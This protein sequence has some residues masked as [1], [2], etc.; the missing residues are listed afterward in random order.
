MAPA[1][2]SGLGIA[3]RIAHLTYRS[4]QELET[5]FSRH[6]QSGEQPLADGRYAVQSYLDHQANKLV[7]RFDAGSY[8][9]LTD[10]MNTHDLGRGRGGVEAALASITGADRGR[11]RRLRPAVSALPAGADRDARRPPATGCT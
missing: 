10:A 9:A 1:R 2:R 3:R 4:E 6:P 7:N 8:V 11:R 5:R